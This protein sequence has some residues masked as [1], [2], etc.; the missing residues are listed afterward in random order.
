MN[1]S[2]IPVFALLACIAS[3]GA[4]APGQVATTAPKSCAELLAR[5]PANSEFMRVQT[6]R[7]AETEQLQMH[8]R[9]DLNH[10]GFVTFGEL[11]QWAK[12]QAA[13]GGEPS[14]QALPLIRQIFEQ[15]DADHDGKISTRET[16]AAAD[17][18]FDRSDTNH[19]GKITP[20]ERCATMNRTVTREV[21]QVK[22]GR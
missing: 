6:K 10:D 7:D 5:M 19:D 14:A 11:Q 17:L 9:L 20:A 4:S 18:A 8:N 2:M 3:A 12:R 13:I 15:G 16:I 21:R 1:H 22:H